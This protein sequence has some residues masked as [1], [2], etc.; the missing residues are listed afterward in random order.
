MAIR[1]GDRVE[2]RGNI[3]MR[4]HFVLKLGGVVFGHADTMEK[5]LEMKAKMEQVMIGTVTI[6]EELIHA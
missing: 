1:I 6:V 4:K 3:G 2:L 5:A